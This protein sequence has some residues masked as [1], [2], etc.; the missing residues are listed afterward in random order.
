MLYWNV[1]GSTFCN[2]LEYFQPKLGWIHSSKTHGYGG[3]TLYHS[4]IHCIS[5]TFLNTK[6]VTVS[7]TDKICALLGLY[8]L[9]AG[10]RQKQTK[11]NGWG[12]GKHYGKKDLSRKAIQSY[13]A[14]SMF[15]A[16][17][18]PSMYPS[19]YYIST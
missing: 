2:F 10:D 16:L 14:D 7:K 1:W 15:C 12:G 13:I 4:F 11:Y 17:Q 18:K 3:L 6:D 5:D 19:I 8:I 9:V